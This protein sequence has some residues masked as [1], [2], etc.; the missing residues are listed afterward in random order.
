MTSCRSPRLPLAAA[1]ALVTLV[2]APAG[3]VAQ[4]GEAVIRGTISSAEGGP[5]AGA[6]I[7][8]MDAE[9]VDRVVAE[10][11]AG[12]DGRFRLDVERGLP[13]SFLL[14]VSAEGFD[15]LEG[16]VELAPGQEGE[17][18]V[19]LVPAG[20][21][22]AQEATAAYN[23]GVRAF[24][25]GDL[26]AA[27]ERFEAALAADPEFARGH[28]GLAQVYL[29]RNQAAAA[30]LEVDLYLAAFPDDVDG[31]RLAFQI[32][33]AAGDEE[34]AARELAA[35]VA[36]GV[37]AEAAGDVYN[38]GV[39]ALREGDREAALARF[40][41][42]LELD[43]SLAAAARA[44]ATVLYEDQRFAEAAATAGRLL[45][46]VPDDAGALKLRFVAL[47]AA[48]DPAADAA[49]DAWA[50]ADPEAAIEQVSE[51]AKEDFEADRREGA[52]KQLLRLLRLQPEVPET[53]YRLGLLYVGGGDETEAA[54]H[55][56]RFLE[57][58]PEHPEAA[59]ARELLQAL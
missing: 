15:L 30:G 53:H 47:E 42:A 50:A 8:L 49:L 48:G 35:L 28:L 4:R 16:P 54:K 41:K 21:T 33:R 59:T 12:D 20:E 58:A 6:R 32:F 31:H 3:A 18:S 55:L 23:E 19:E 25:E 11:T 9:R 1:L 14:R 40:E 24:Q 5:I 39:A 57:L 36:A 34:K 46:R 38:D 29:R 51:W 45:E 7:E 27:A 2:L 10:A 44:I 22:A 52:E 17:V 56:R 13:G 37:G 26:D 43:P